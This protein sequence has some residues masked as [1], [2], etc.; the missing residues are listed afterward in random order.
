MAATRFRVSDD[1]TPADYLETEGLP[2]EAI[3]AEFAATLNRLAGHRV[4]CL[5]SVQVEEGK[6]TTIGLGD[7]FV[8]GFLP[9]LVETE[10][11]TQKESDDEYRNQ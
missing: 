10:Q 5:P 3:G 11:E 2:V 4:C 6:G 1:F 9:A 8:G 7:A